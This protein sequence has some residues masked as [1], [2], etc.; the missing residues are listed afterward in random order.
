MIRWRRTAEEASRTRSIRWAPRAASDGAERT[1]T[2]LTRLWLFA[3]ALAALCFGT[4]TIWRIAAEHFAPD[5]SDFRVPVSPYPG[6][7]KIR[8]GNLNGIPFAIPSNYLHF[9]IGYHDKSI[10]DP[11]KPPNYYDDKTYEDSIQNFSLY[12]RWPDLEPRGLETEESF[13]DSIREPGEHAWF[14]VSVNDDYVHSPR[15]PETPENGLARILTSKVERLPGNNRSNWRPSIYDPETDGGRHLPDVYYE[16]RGEDSETGLQ[17]AVPVG[18]HTGEAHIWNKA[19]YWRGDHRNI[20]NPLIMCSHGAYPNPQTAH[21]CRHE[22][23]FPDLEANVSVYYTSNWLPKWRE[24]QEKVKEFVMS[25]RV[26]LE[27]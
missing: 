19:I 26:D 14:A 24:I 8:K 2:S 25:F 21:R 11:D 9:P 17:W 22:F 16:L 12:V 23:E 1:S 4:V 13:S 27:Q 3:V 5:Q 10:W 6:S 18:P 15:P 20:V 7:T